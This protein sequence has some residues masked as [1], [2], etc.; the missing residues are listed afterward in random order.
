MNHKIIQYLQQ[1]TCATICCVDEQ[2]KPWCF[3]CF[4][5]FNAADGLLYFKSHADAHHSSIIQK[6]PL[7]AG[8]V[9]PD[10]LNKLLIKGVQLEGMVLK[11]LHPKAVTGFSYY[12]KK[13]PQALAIAGKV[14][15]I[16]IEHIKM[17]DSTLGFGKKI[18]WYRNEPPAIL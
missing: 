14:W 16:Q 2:G 9:L 10:K 4:Y 1:E 11:D 3:S 6:N 8:T 15:T 18:P 13:N 7:V 5:V 17:T 12:H